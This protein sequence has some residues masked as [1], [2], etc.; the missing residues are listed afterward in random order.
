MFLC[1]YI[2]VCAPTHTRCLLRVLKEYGAPTREL[3]KQWLKGK[4]AFS[5]YIFGFPGAQRSKYGAYLRLRGG[6]AGVVGAVYVCV[7]AC[8]H[9]D[10]KRSHP[11]SSAHAHHC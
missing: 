9:E 1:V 2:C 6:M 10:H 11:G 7:R 3:T 4:Q 8:V 5:D